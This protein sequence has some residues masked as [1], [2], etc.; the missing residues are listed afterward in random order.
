MAINLF[1][2]LEIP[3]R[4]HN[5]LNTISHSD[6]GDQNLITLTG[7]PALRSIPG[8]QQPSPRILVKRQEIQALDQPPEHPS[9]LNKLPVIHLGEK[10]EASN[11]SR[12]EPFSSSLSTILLAS[13]PP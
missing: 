4:S 3:I 6:A 7:L 11:R 8:F 9:L 5:L 10:L 2:S 12:A 1:N 13:E